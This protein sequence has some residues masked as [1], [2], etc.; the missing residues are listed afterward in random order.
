MT[1][2][3]PVLSAGNYSEKNRPQ[4]LES[5]FLTFSEVAGQLEAS[6][7]ELQNQVTCLT[8][9]LASA[10]SE[11]LKQLAE[12][13]CLANRLERLLNLLPGGVVVLDGDGAVQ[14]CNP[15][16]VEIL[17]ES[18]RGKRWNEVAMRTFVSCDEGVREVTTTDGR[19]LNISTASLGSEPGR[20]LL[21]NDVTETRILQESLNRHRRL[22][23]MG[24]MAASLAHQIRTPLASAL[25]YVS[26]LASEHIS[27]ADR[28]RFS[29]KVL[30]RL[31][32]LDRLVNDMLLFARGGGPRDDEIAVNDLVQAIYQTSE[33]HV[34][35]G[36]CNLEVEINENTKSVSLMGN[37]EALLSAFQNLIINAIEVCGQ[38]GKLLLKAEKNGVNTLN[39]SLTDD[40]PGV[41]LELQE[42]LFD[43]FFTTRPQGTGLGL[44]AVRAIASAHGGSVWLESAHG[45]G[46]TFGLRL[47][48]SN[49]QEALPSCVKRSTSIGM[50]FHEKKNDNAQTACFR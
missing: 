20:I 41:P 49:I 21:I 2:M 45:Q 22:S 26:H 30:S 17:G 7:R 5:A 15:V 46:A 12:K 36:G 44:A 24:E 40:G 10:R 11:R 18:P 32:H 34:L 48:V 1:E 47:P 23:S 27:D 28:C 6:Y 8:A 16:A 19:H 13:E 4:E 9:E 25:L 43:P 14:E 37:R 33:P 39:M 42:R 29:E 35:S 3:T 50:V 38:G 31:R